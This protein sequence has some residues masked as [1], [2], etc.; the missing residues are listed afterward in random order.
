MP[1]ARQGERGPSVSVFSERA[2]ATTASGLP[3]PVFARADD[4]HSGAASEE[5]GR[6]PFTRGIRSGMYQDRPWTMRQLAGF[7]SAADTNTRY[8][9]LLAAGATGVNGV[10]DYPS[11]RAFD[12]D[13]P[14]ARSDVGRGGV[15]VDVRDDFEEL[16]AG[17]PLD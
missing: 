16:F 1:A 4:V 17:I 7:G 13:H 2:E 3:L 5:P 11:L 15:A 10:F 9:S 8:R 14:L 12:S 6:F